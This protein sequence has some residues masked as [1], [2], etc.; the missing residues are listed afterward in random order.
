MNNVF[1]SIV[2]PAYKNL[3]LF[4]KALLSVLRQEFVD[5]EVVI[6][7]DSTDN[8]IMEY[9]FNINDKRIR[10]YKNSS[11]RGAVKNWNYGISL[12]KAD[13]VILLH[14]DE[15]FVGD[16]YLK[17]CFEIINQT[18]CDVVISNVFVEFYNGT[19][20][21][22]EKSIGL[23]KVICKYFPEILYLVNVIGP[24]ATIIAKMQCITKFDENL[25]LLVDVDWYINI[26]RSKKISFIKEE[27]IC[28]IF[29]H[30]DQISM[31]IDRN[32]LRKKEELYI[33]NKYRYMNVIFFLRWAIFILLGR[34][35]VIK[36]I[37]WR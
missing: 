32:V 29:G 6:V 35:S 3:I 21:S 34:V 17:K 4:K 15:S 8:K 13:Y 37:I 23:K 27:C 28:S 24:T 10:Y 31:K 7:D 22:N 9:L 33:S 18:N 25:V 11:P 19:R 16:N 20:K 30:E 5:Y 1:F 36:K 12:A 2:I 26:I 14:H